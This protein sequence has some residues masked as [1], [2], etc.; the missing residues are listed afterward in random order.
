MSFAILWAN[1]VASSGIGIGVAIGLFIGL[2]IR[3]SRGNTEG[4]I[5][6]SVLL[7]AAFA[8][9]AVMVVSGLVKTVMG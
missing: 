3:K 2:S 5:N 7:T 4:L 8:G 9:I 6:G 1:I